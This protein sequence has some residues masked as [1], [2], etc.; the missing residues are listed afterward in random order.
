MSYYE[1]SQEPMILDAGHVDLPLNTQVV[2]QAN[3]KLEDIERTVILET[4]K[5]KGFNRTHAAKTLGIG[6]RTL[7]RKLKQYGAAGIGLK[8]GLLF[9]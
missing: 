6:I 5:Q 9:S 8:D 1:T 2:F 4:L 3:A 7:Q